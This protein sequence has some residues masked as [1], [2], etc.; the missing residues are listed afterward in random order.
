[1]YNPKCLHLTSTTSY[2]VTD[3]KQ[4]GNYLET[5]VCETWYDQKIETVWDDFHILKIKNTMSDL[6]NILMD[7][8]TYASE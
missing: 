3:L 6:D 5:E 2:S 4:E 1:M 7:A 8:W